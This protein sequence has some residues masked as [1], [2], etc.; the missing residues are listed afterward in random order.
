[1]ETKKLIGKPLQPARP[2]RHLTSPPGAVFPFN[3]QNEYTCNTQC[4]QSGVSR[5]LCCLTDFLSRGS[6]HGCVKRMECKPF[7]KVLM[8]NNIS[9]QL[10][11]RESNTAEISY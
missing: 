7:L 8:N 6:V 5:D 3:F 1:M 11:K 10:K 4:L 2:V 9:L